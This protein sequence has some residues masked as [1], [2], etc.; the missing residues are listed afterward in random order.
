MKTT[1]MDRQIPLQDGR[2]LGYCDIHPP[3]GK[4]V[5]YAHGFPGSRLD[6]ILAERTAA[7]RRMGI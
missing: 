2:L 6:A 7:E 1:V 3:G 4:P 5:F